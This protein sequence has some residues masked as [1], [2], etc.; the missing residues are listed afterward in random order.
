MHERE[1]DRTNLTGA[2]DRLDLGV[3]RGIITAEQRDAL[4]AIDLDG[5]VG[6]VK[7]ARRGLNTVTVAYWAGAIAVLTAFGSFLVSRWQVLGPAG[8]LV[9]ALV[10][11]VLFAGTARWLDRE[12]FRMAAA[13]ATLLVVGMTPIVTWSLLSLT[14]LWDLY[15]AGRQT[16]YIE[17]FD[18]LWSQLRW[19]P[20]DFATI[21]AALVALRRVRVGVLALPIAAALS[22][23]A[24]HIIALIIEPEFANA[25]GGRLPLVLSTCLFAIAYTLDVRTTDGE[26]YAVWFYIAAVIALIMALGGFWR[27]ASVVAA[28]GTL[29]AATILAFAAVKLRRRILVLAAF[30]GFVAYLGYLAFDVFEDA[31]AFPVALAT[32]GIVVILAAVG[33]QKRYPSLVRG[34]ATPGPRGIRGAPIALAGAIVIAVAL[35]A[36]GISDARARIAENYWREAFYRRRSHNMQKYPD[37]YRTPTGYRGRPLRV[38]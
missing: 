16:L 23:A 15:P 5:S 3:E 7:E 35:T 10:Y 18:P 2:M 27:G 25:L 8:V 1:I 26:D 30:I 9:V 36:A 20:I 14:G 32:I 21:L 6:D 34:A 33:L 29:L 31:V 38:P 11:A 13:I 22:A 12:G 17:I 28:H 24:G 19:L 4:R 37:L